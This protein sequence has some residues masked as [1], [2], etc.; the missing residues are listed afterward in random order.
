MDLKKFN[1][2]AINSIYKTAEIGLSS[3]SNV[4]EE[5][6]HSALKEELRNE[7][8]GY[9]NF[10]SNFSTFIVSNGYEIKDV[11]PVKKAFMWTSIKLNTMTNDSASHVA[12]LMIKGTVMGIT[13]M[14]EMLNSKGGA[15][16]SEILKY[17]EE[18]KNLM[19]KYEQEL[20]KYL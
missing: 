17:A 14:Q 5:V 12:Q 4:S 19:E 20:K 11:N 7:Y 16:D 18:L 15:I 3:I 8:E 6:E 10:I 9:E 13:E 2:E 1:Q